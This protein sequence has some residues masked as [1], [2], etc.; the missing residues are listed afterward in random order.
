[1]LHPFS[2]YPSL[3]VLLSLAYFTPHF[4]KAS[5]TYTIWRNTYRHRHSLENTLFTFVQVIPVQKG[6]PSCKRLPPLLG[7]PKVNHRAE[8]GTNQRLDSSEGCS[9]GRGSVFCSRGGFCL[10]WL[11]KSVP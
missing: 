1:M 2:V 5:A 11:V 9:G 4:T 3:D 8:K 7:R 6:Q 10:V